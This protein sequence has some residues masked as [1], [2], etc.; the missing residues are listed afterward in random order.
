MYIVIRDLALTALFVYGLLAGGELL[1]NGAVYKDCLQYGY[2]AP[3]PWL[4]IKIKCEVVR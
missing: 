2:S 3:Y 1:A 4:K